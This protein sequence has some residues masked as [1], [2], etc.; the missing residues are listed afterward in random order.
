M[1]AGGVIAIAVPLALMLVARRYVVAGLRFG[2]I[3]DT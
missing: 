2:V 1:A 3:R